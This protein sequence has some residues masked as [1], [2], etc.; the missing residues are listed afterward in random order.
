[1]FFPW[2]HLLFEPAVCEAFYRKHHGRKST[3]AWVNHLTAAEY[4]E[5]CGELGLHVDALR[6]STTP[7]DVPLYARFEEKLG[8]YPALDLETDFLWLTLRKRTSSR[9]RLRRSWLKL[10]K[11]SQYGSR[12]ELRR[13][14]WHLRKDL[15]SWWQPRAVNSTQASAVAVGLNYVDR[16]RSLDDQLDRLRAQS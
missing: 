8:R 4:V 1:V 14:L 12:L 2:P 9:A 3:F 11:Q 13:R 6:R 15:R 7:I 10:S 5:A 16:Q